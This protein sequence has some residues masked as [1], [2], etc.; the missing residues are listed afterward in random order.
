MYKGT[1]EKPHFPQ[2]LLFKSKLQILI[3]TF[4]S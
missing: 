3:N 1:K 4:L 2:K